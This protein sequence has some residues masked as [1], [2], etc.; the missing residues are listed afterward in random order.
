MAF[1]SITS[2]TSA[3]WFRG[4]DHMK[5]P[6]LLTHLTTCAAV[7]LGLWFLTW[8]SPYRLSTWAG[9]GFLYLAGC[10]PKVNVSGFPGRSHI[11][12]YNPSWDIIQCHLHWTLFLVTKFCPGSRGAEVFPCQSGVVRFWMTWWAVVVICGKCNQ[13][14]R[15]HAYSS[16]I[17]LHFSKNPSLPAHLH[18]RSGVP[19]GFHNPYGGQVTAL[20][21]LPPTKRG[22]S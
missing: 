10:V 9:S 18:T 3:G 17:Y 21:F 19:T 12:F 2:R 7:S 8:T 20:P 6:S 4:W 11:N 5:A 15:V 22:S 1:C 16:F 14:Y 13:P